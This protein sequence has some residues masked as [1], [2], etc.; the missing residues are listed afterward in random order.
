[1]TRYFCGNKG[2]GH[3][4]PLKSVIIVDIYNDLAG[5]IIL[6]NWCIGGKD[7]ANV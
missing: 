3:P 4:H 6:G 1:M 7:T 2:I 5:K